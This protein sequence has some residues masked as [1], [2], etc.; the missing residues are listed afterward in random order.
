M[1]II[2]ALAEKLGYEK[3]NAQLKSAYAVLPIGVRAGAP[4]KHATDTTKLIDAARTNEVVYACISTKQ[5]TAVDPRLFVERRERDNTWREVEGHPLRRL[6]MRPNADM[7]EVAFW[8]WFIASREISGEFYAE[9]V[10]T[11]KNGPPVNLYPLNPALVSPVPA[12]DGTVSEYEFKLGSY[13]ERIPAEN[14]LVWRNVDIGNEYRGLS[15]LA[16]ALGAVQGDI[17]QTD[18]VQKFFQ[19]GGVPSGYMKIK[20][21][22]VTSIEADEIRE[23][24]RAKFSPQLGGNMSD[25]AVLDENADFEVLG[26]R[27]N[28]LQSEELRSVAESRICMVFGVPPLVIYA[29]IGMLRSIQSNLREA[30]QQF[31][32]STLTPEYKA[33]RQWLTARL[34]PEFESDDLV[35]GERVRCQWDMSQVAAMQDDVDA[36]QNRARENYTAGGI[37]RNEFRAVIGM[38]ADDARGNDYASVSQ[39][40]LGASSAGKAAP[41]LLAKVARMPTL[42]KDAADQIDGNREK[43]VK[44]AKPKI[45]TYLM[46]EYMQAAKTYEDTGNTSKALATTDDGEQIQRVMNPY[47]KL[48]MRASYEDANTLLSEFDISVSF[49]LSNP[50]VADTIDTLLT[51]VKDITDTTRE[52]LRTAIQNGLDAGKSISQIAADIRANA[53]D[54]SAA[55]AETTAR[56]ETATA[57]TSGALLAYEETGVVQEV[58]WLATLD[59]KTSEVC[60]RLNGKRITLEQAQKGGFGNGIKGP[61]AHPNCRSVILPVV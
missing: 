31:W 52:E 27:L 58:E 32:D 38:P 12:S 16:V 10:R 18:Y 3:R 1:N 7:D 51:M 34:L 19:V 5:R 14:M 53:P 23:K 28:E 45:E 4:V 59:D 13:R 56:T 60:Q 47:Y 26:A 54:Y 50:R 37:T 49:D 8:Q 48:A 29:Y 42:T 43:I 6:V 33:A 40:M 2:D 25:I 44:K 9:I 22:T 46:G 39:P 21:R 24:W 17:A 36:I 35:L 61:P 11:T 20:G 41:A 55:R 15:P 57:Y 30:W